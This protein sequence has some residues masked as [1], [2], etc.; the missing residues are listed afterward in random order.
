MVSIIE[1]EKAVGLKIDLGCGPNKKEGF[2]GVDSIEFDGV[3]HVFDIGTDVWPFEDGSVTE[4]NCSHCLEH[5]T[6]KQRCWFANELYRVLAKG[7]TCSLTTPSW[8]SGRAYG[9]PTHQWPPISEWFYW[10]LNREW[11]EGQAPHTDKKHCDWGY[12]C[13]FD[14]TLGYLLDPET[15]QRNDEYKTFALKHYTESSQD[16]MA[17]VTKR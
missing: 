12:D 10:Y 4:A 14:H 6:P 11:R 8:R 1:A 17:T 16:I 9:D 3:D 2:L 7:G 15:A 5:L 13:D